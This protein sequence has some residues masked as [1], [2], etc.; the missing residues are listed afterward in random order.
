MKKFAV[1]LLVI[2]LGIGAWLYFGGLDRV[3]QSRVRTS[4][5][6][7]GVPEPL[8]DCMSPR[9]VDRLSLNQL[10]K[11]ERIRAEE[12]ELA[13]PLSA[14][15]AIARLQ[16]VDDREAVQVVAGAAAGCTLELLLSGK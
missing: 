15:Q 1:V 16:R 13:V 4:L 10:R 7:A 3:T 12:D 5:V 2:A 11:L 14:Q 8:A 6:E 9:M